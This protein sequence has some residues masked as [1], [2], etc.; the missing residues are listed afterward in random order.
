MPLRAVLEPMRGWRSTLDERD[1]PG[2]Q[3]LVDVPGLRR[4]Q[5]S[6]EH[7]AVA[8][9]LDVVVSLTLAAS[10]NE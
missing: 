2:Q 6:E 3:G 9:E 5:L 10:I 7:N 1:V 8:V 4:R